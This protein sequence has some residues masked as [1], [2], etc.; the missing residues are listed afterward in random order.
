M[1]IGEYVYLA[2]M[3][4]SQCQGSFLI[5]EYDLSKSLSD[6]WKNHSVSLQ[7]FFCCQN[8]NNL[9]LK[10]EKDKVINPSTPRQTNVVNGEFNKNVL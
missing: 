9:I 5:K 3:L 1:E 2:R 7:F 4:Y 6:A 10:N 8:F